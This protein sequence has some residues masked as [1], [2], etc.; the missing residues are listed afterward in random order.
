MG[1]RVRPPEWAGGHRQAVSHTLRL[2]GREQIT[3]RDTAGTRNRCSFTHSEYCS[4]AGERVTD[5]PP[6]SVLLR[7]NCTD[8]T[9]MH[10]GWCLRVRVLEVIS[11]CLNFPIKTC[12][13]ISSPQPATSVTNPRLAHFPSGPLPPPKCLDPD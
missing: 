1:E 12:P 4:F 9:H 6:S 10:S 8:R 3:S 11:S 2:L 7:P 5:Y 13:F